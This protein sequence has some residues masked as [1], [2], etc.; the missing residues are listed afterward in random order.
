MTKILVLGGCGR[1]GKI[2]AADLAK[3]YDVHTADISN[4]PDILMDPFEH[5]NDVDM[6][7][8][9]LVVGALPSVEGYH[10]LQASLA[11]G[12]SYVDLSFTD[13]DFG[14][15]HD[16]AVK[17]GVT[18]LHDCGVAPGLSHL[19]AGRAIALGADEIYISVGGVAAKARDDYV[20]TWNPEDLLEEYTRPA[21]IVV[22]GQVVTVPALSGQIEE[23]IPGIDNAGR[24]NTFY[25]DGLRSLLSKAG[26]VRRME[27]RTMRWPGHTEKAFPLIYSGDFVAGMRNIYPEGNNDLL[28]MKIRARW[29]SRSWASTYSC[30]TRTCR[31][32]SRSTMRGS[33]MTAR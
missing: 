23:V 7:L 21:R 28:A 30:P 24:L 16:D 32:A 5:F 4:E 15:L 19:V 12:T 14:L 20:I 13:D 18:V 22:D 9:D 2:I 10:G 29:T 8:Y 26:P 31:S 17:A 27:E 1:Q 3:R 25:S 33:S 11:A 6:S